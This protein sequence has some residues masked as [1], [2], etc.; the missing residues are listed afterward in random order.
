[1]HIDMMHIGKTDSNHAC[2][3]S[4]LSEEKKSV[5][6]L[7]LELIETYWSWKLSYDLPDKFKAILTS[8][9]KDK[10]FCAGNL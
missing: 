2:C 5:K 3:L 8:V 10:S 1:M 4:I 7:S 6:S 9:R